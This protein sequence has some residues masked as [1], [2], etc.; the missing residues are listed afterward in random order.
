[1]SV[2]LRE[3]KAREQ[4]EREGGDGGRENGGGREGGVGVWICERFFYMLT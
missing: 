3:G 2:R 1:V 4:G